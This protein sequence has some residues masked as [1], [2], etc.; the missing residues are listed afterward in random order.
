M[1]SL[2]KFMMGSR[3]H[4]NT[5]ADGYALF[6][7]SQQELISLRRSLPTWY[8]RGSARSVM[9]QSAMVSRH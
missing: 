5:G 9:A 7:T 6:R 2:S 4:K 8:L 3:Q 1:A